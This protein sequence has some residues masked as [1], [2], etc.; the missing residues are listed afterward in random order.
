VAKS[1][2]VKG[3]GAMLCPLVVEPDQ[4]SCLK[5]P[6]IMRKAILSVNQFT[7]QGY[8][9]YNFMKLGLLLQRADSP[10]IEPG[11]KFLSAGAYLPLQ[12]AAAPGP[13]GS[14]AQNVGKLKEMER[15]GW[16]Q[17]TGD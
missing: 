14:E 15:G 3:A 13:G 10:E 4:K 12:P 11:A 2:Q 9:L 8:L 1:G 6:P 7:A 5:H 17:T 16:N